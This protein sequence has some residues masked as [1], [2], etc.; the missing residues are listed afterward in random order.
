MPPALLRTIE[1]TAFSTWIRDSPSLFGFWFILS[2]HALGMAL[3]VGAS[4]V[5]ALRILGVARDVPLSTLRRLYPLIW[6]GFW[7]QI[8]SG[9]L[10][11]FFGAAMLRYAVQEFAAPRAP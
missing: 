5:I 3:L 4:T 9:V 7:V 11:I 2:F 6:A 1:E 8:V 10:L